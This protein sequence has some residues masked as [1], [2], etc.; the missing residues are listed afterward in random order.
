MTGRRPFTLLAAA[1][2]LLMAL[3]H[4]YRVLLSHFQV[5]LGT[6]PI[7]EWVSIIAIVVTGVL[8]LMLFRESRS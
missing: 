2:F 5:I 1:I 3:I 7:P 6:H 4:L 8:S